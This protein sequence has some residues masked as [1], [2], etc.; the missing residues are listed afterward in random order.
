MGEVSRREKGRG[1]KRSR[2]GWTDFSG[3]NLNFVIGCTPVS[4]GCANCYARRLYER[5]GK[6]FSKVVIY[7][8]KLE[9]LKTQAFPQ[10]GNRRGPGKRPMCFIV[11]MGDLFH[12][13]VPDEFILEALDIMAARDDVIWQVLTKR[14]RRMS[15]C[16]RNWSHQ[17]QKLLPSNVWLGISAEDQQTF[18]ERVKWRNWITA[19][20]FWVSLEPLLEAINLRRDLLWSVDWAVIGGESGPGHRPMKMEWVEAIYEECRILGIP[21]FGKQESSLYPGKPLLIDRHEIHEWPEMA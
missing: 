14:P 4:T 2:I 9:G 15:E 21:F 20:I 8:E 5:W 19:K 16:T 12:E 6:D 17:R 10:D 1:V 13:K 3:G 18:G 11:D 7:P